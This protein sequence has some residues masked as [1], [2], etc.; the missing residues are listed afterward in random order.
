M[1]RPGCV[2]P[3]PPACSEGRKGALVQQ[4]LSAKEAS[5]KTFSQIGSE[6][7]CTNVYTA[8]LFYNQAQL[9]E[10]TVRAL[11]QAVPALTE[12]MLAEMQKA[13]SRR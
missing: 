9:K 11:A 12:E 8:S 10:G 7:G 5:Q 13:P 2:K 3:A 6:I 1:D 4:L